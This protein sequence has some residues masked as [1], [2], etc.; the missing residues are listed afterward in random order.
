MSAW[1]AAILTTVG[2]VIGTLLGLLPIRALTIR[3]TAGPVGA[4]HMPFVAD[5]PFLVL[6]AL[7]LR[8]S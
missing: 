2:A 1:Q 7:G 3:F 5:W 8:C 4:S 6:L